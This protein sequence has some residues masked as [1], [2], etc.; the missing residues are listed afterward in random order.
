MDTSKEYILMC[1]KATEIQKIH[2]VDWANFP[3]TSHEFDFGDY[4]GLLQNGAWSG[5]AYDGESTYGA[6]PE[7]VIWILQQDQLQE[8]MDLRVCFTEVNGEAHYS[9][10]P[11]IVLPTTVV[12][13]SMEQLWLAF[14]MKDKYGKIWNG[15]EWQKATNMCH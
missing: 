14:V 5:H 11:D 9:I 1:E 10:F 13:I 8:M 6:N 15:E 7:K 12:Y 4:Y 2:R 3:I